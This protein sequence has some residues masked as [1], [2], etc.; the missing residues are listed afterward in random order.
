MWGLLNEK[1]AETREWRALR[2]ASHLEVKLVL[3]RARP[4]GRAITYARRLLLICCAHCPNDV[5][6][7]PIYNNVTL[8]QPTCRP[9]HITAIPPPLSCIPHPAAAAAAAAACCSLA[10][11]AHYGTDYP[12][13]SCIL[14]P[15]LVRVT[16]K[17]PINTFQ[18]NTTVIVF[19]KTSF[20]CYL[21]LSAPLLP[22][23]NFSF[24]FTVT[25]SHSV[26][27]PRS[28]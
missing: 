25:K 26:S 14:K 5:L 21:P 2:C 6:S 20:P 24:H 27:P 7:A 22:S 28:N 18:A 4:R 19:K 13:P 23:V 3:W 15:K 11:H 1:V 9:S 16:Q 8:N 12:S 10:S 17:K